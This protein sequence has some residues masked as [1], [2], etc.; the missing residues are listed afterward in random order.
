MY[1]L[2]RECF[3]SI[4]KDSAIKNRN[5]FEKFLSEVEVLSSL[6]NYERSK[7]CDCLWIKVYTDGMYVIKEGE[8]GD[9]FYMIIEGKAEA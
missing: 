3:N 1:S 8:R 5:A 6:D 9:T 7:L 2:D 4:V